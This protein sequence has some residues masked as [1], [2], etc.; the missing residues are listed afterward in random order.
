MARPRYFEGVPNFPTIPLLERFDKHQVNI[1]LHRTDGLARLMREGKRRSR[2]P[3]VVLHRLLGSVGEPINPEGWLWYHREVG[4]GVPDCRTWWQ[5]ETGG[6]YYAPARRNATEAGSASRPFFGIRPELSTLTANCWRCHIGQSVHCRQLARTDA[7]R[8]WRPPALYRR[9]ILCNIRANILPVTGAGATK[10]VITG[11]PACDDV[12]NI[13]GHRLG[14]AEVES[15]L[16]A[17]ATS[18][19]GGGGWLSA[20]H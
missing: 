14:T 5:T 8:L 17:H 6:Y 7:H 3:Q 12:L 19:R 9:L 20:R 15:A 11:L 13:S 10:T 18:R 4:E 16:V 1:F 2:G